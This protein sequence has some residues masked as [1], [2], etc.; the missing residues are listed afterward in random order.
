MSGWEGAPSGLLCA[1]VPKSN[2][3]LGSEASGP[4]A[5]REVFKAGKHRHAEIVSGL[6][7]TGFFFAYSSLYPAE[8]R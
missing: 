5:K 4:P 8:G 2:C 6:L 3:F 1:A 7:M